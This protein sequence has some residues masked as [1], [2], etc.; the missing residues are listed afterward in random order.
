[1]EF[2]ITSKIWT[3]NAEAELYFQSQRDFFSFSSKTQT[4]TLGGS[5]YVAKP[6]EK[7]RGSL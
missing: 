4:A 1:V 5:Y 2:T 7:A 6:H 3:E